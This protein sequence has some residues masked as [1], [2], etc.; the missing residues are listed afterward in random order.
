MLTELLSS[1][2]EVGLLAVDAAIGGRGDNLRTSGASA[3]GGGEAGAPRN[4]PLK[5]EEQ[6]TVSPPAGEAGGAP[7]KPPLSRSM[8][9]LVEAAAGSKWEEGKLKKVSPERGGFAPPELGWS[10]RAPMPRLQKSCMSE[11]RLSLAE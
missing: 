9:P 1:L 3:G 7:K 2:S 11:I 10:R 6:V 5:V 8:P 4:D